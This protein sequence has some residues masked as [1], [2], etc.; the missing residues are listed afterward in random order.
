MFTTHV[1]DI[2]SGLTEIPRKSDVWSMC[3]I[4]G[5]RSSMLEE[6]LF[7]TVQRFHIFL[8]VG[9]S[10]GSVVERRWVGPAIPMICGQS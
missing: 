8:E 10:Q 9:W 4:T 2:P 5:Y 7:C 1:A 3:G 6:V